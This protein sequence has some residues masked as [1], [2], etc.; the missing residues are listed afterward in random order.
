M[1]LHRNVLSRLATVLIHWSQRLLTCSK[2]Y[3][4]ILM[5]TSGPDYLIVSVQLSSASVS[6]FNSYRNAPRQVRALPEFLKWCIYLTPQIGRQ[7]N[8][9][10]EEKKEDKVW[11]QEVGCDEHHSFGVWWTPHFGGSLF[12]HAGISQGQGDPEVSDEPCSSFNSLKDLEQSLI[13]HNQSFLLIWEQVSEHT[14]GWDND[15]T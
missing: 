11:W 9:V 5:N 1:S 7:W 14:N 3:G 12:S 10:V 4:P 8:W 15:F 13:L 6:T 2:F